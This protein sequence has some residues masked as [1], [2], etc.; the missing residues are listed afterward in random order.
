MAEDIRIWKILAGDNLCELSKSRLDIE[1]RIET[2]IEKDITIISNNLL[3][4]GR[5]TVTDYGGIIDLLCLDNNGDVTIIE[6]KRD[7]TPREVVA[8]TLDYASWV[9]K[10]SNDRVTEIANQYLKENGPLEK[11]FQSYFQTELPEILNE[12]HKI[13]ILASDIDSSSERIINYLSESYGVAINAIKF[14]YFRNNQNDEFLARIFLIDPG[15][16]EVRT[17][18][19]P[20]TKRKPRLNYEELHAIAEQ[21]GV[22]EIYNRICEGLKPFFKTYTTQSSL[23]FEAITEKG[24]KSIISLIPQESDPENGLRFQVYLSRFANFFDISEDRVSSLFSSKEKWEYFK[25][26]PPEWSGFKGFNACCFCSV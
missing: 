26:A 16:V 23:G 13:L 15:Q 6:L 18:N 8:Q 24:R 21:K 19:I 25:N 4:I 14:Q 22:D 9:N 7:K 11:T 2:W 3:I 1:E 12:N 10:L 20:S 17:R 5:Q